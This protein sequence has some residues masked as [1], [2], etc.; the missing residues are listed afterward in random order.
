MSGEGLHKKSPRS[1]NKPLRRSATDRPLAS[2]KTPKSRRTRSVVVSPVTGSSSGDDSE[3][4]GNTSLNLA[5]PRIPRDKKRSS[6]S[7]ALKSSGAGGSSS[8]S[9]GSRDEVPDMDWTKMGPSSNDSSSSN[10]SPKKAG[11]T[12]SL[13]AANN[14]ISEVNSEDGSSDD[15]DQAEPRRSSCAKNPNEKPEMDWGAHCKEVEE[16]AA[17]KKTPSRS[18]PKNAL[19]GKSLSNNAL[20]SKTKNSP[21]SFKS[22]AAKLA[23]PG[24]KKPSMK[25][26]KIPAMS[27]LLQIMAMDS[28]FV[29]AVP[30][31][32]AELLK[33]PKPASRQSSRE[34]SRR[35][36]GKSRGSSARSGMTDTSD[37]SSGADSNNSAGFD[38]D[39]D[40]DVEINS[41]NYHGDNRKE[42]QRTSTRTKQPRVSRTQRLQAFS[43]DV[44]RGNAQPPAR[45]NGEG[46]GDQTPASPK[47]RNTVDELTMRR[48]KRAQDL[49]SPS[50]LT[51]PG[52]GMRKA[53]GP[54]A[55]GRENIPIISTSFDDADIL[56]SRNRNGER[57]RRGNSRPVAENNVVH[58]L[59]T[60]R[61]TARKALAPS[62]FELDYEGDNPLGQPQTMGRNRPKGRSGSMGFLLMDDDDDEEEKF[63]PLVN[64]S[65]H[66]GRRQTRHSDMARIESNLDDDNDAMG[67][68]ERSARVRRGQGGATRYGRQSLRNNDNDADEDFHNNSSM[69]DRSSARRNRGRSLQEL[70]ME[71]PMQQRRQSRASSLRSLKLPHEDDIDEMSTSSRSS[72][73]GQNGR[74]GLAQNS[75]DFDDDAS[76]GSI[77]STD[78]ARR[79]SSSTSRNGRYGYTNDRLTLSCVPSQPKKS[80]GLA[81]LLYC[82]PLDL[83]GDDEESK[84]TDDT[85]GFTLDD[86]E[87]RDLNNSPVSVTTVNNEP[88]KNAAT[89]GEETVDKAQAKKDY[90]KAKLA[91][92][93]AQGDGAA[94][95]PRRRNSVGY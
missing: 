16:D 28:N 33:K 73:G 2:P 18:T 78:S 80:V 36:V 91:G 63:D 29:G 35:Q 83:M 77:S 70:P 11:S 64:R 92:K 67:Q 40:H 5:L 71:S 61:R 85:E 37:R 14:S 48:R 76:I 75:N 79:R 86:D 89:E 58:A 51:P 8:R 22:R 32:P 65:D 17:P 13:G 54:S 6:S 81:A 34:A 30:Q 68:S 88:D 42:R 72:R 41:T 15:N 69:V 62:P 94:P 7:R 27:P 57:V 60:P 55:V 10:K 25:V 56:S 52:G 44:T 26:G 31:V 19:K 66:G 87:P 1:A 84:N 95:R 23:S 39:N 90:W 49:K 46:K 20:E 59:V 4:S 53:R 38:Q 47:R 50:A 12:T 45:R 93:T 21:G 24:K 82:K 9:L 43:D 74:R 3:G